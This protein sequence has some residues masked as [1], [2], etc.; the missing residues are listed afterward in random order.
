VSCIECTS[1]C[2]E[3]VGWKLG[4]LEVL[5]VGG[6]YSPNHQSGRWRRLLSY[7]APDSPV[8]QPRHPTVRVRPLELWHVGPPNSPVV[9]QTGSVHCPVRLL[10]PALT[11]RAQLHCSLFTVDFCRRPLAHLAVASLA[12]RTVRC[13]TS[14]PV[15]H[16]TVR[17]IIAERQSQKPEGDK[18]GVDLLGAPDTEQSGAPDQDC[19]RLSFAL[20]IWILSWTF[21]WFVLNLWHL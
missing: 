13:Y 15:L 19:L 14:S 9:H 5:V 4:C 16:R 7:G 8:R 2:I 11:L 1:S 12:H 18:F 3:C 10:P 21:Y 6:I 17:W 20:F